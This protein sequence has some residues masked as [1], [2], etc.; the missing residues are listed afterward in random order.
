MTSAVVAAGT[1]EQSTQEEKTS[2]AMRLQFNDEG[3]IGHES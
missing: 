1:S 2:R 3:E